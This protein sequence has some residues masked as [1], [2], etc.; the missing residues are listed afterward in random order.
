MAWKEMRVLMDHLDLL[1]VE[2]TAFVISYLYSSDVLSDFYADLWWCFRV[3]LVSVVLLAQVDQQVFL[4]A[5]D[6][7]DLQA[8]LERKEDQ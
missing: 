2:F 7:K 1:W 4:D 6:L 3:L 5:L 8:H